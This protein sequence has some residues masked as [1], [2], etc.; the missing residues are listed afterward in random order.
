VDVEVTT[1]EGGVLVLELAEGAALYRVRV[2]EHSLRDIE[3][4]LARRRAMGRY[5]TATREEHTCSLA[6]GH[7]EPS[8]LCRAC[9]QTWP[10]VS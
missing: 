2:T 4:E 6:P 7:G 3:F 10:V 8:H 9:A 5:C 1:R